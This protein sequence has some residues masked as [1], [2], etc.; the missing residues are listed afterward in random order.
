MA[1]EALAVQLNGSAYVSPACHVRKVESYK[2]V[3]EVCC[4][5]VAT[6]SRIV[7][8]E[9]QTKGFDGDCGDIAMRFIIGGICIRRHAIAH[10]RLADTRCGAYE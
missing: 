2:L 6:G 10:V 4:I 7:N 5:L 1:F 9:M 3:N 8:F